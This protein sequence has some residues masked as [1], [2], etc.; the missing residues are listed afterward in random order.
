MN[1][2]PVGIGC[3]A[4]LAEG[5]AFYWPQN[6]HVVVNSQSDSA[7]ADDAGRLCKLYLFAHCCMFPNHESINQHNYD[8]LERK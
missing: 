7:C 5:D 6:C 8:I 4:F 3:Y 1:Y 2:G